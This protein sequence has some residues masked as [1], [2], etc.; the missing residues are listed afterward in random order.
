[1]C[2]PDAWPVN[3]Q[4]R[5]ALGGPHI[6]SGGQQSPGLVALSVACL[7]FTDLR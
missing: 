5:Q 6:L 7:S 1:M 4:P 3:P 2:D